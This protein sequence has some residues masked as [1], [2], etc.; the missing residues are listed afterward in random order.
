MLL[1]KR[2][3]VLLFFSFLHLCRVTIDS[4]CCFSY[5]RCT[6]K[7]RFEH[8][9]N[10]VDALGLLLHNLPF[11]KEVAAFFFFNLCFNL[12]GGES[13]RAVALSYIV[14]EERALLSEFFFLP[15]VNL[16]SFF[17]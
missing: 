10:R 6:V 14:E 15:L 2:A 5:T 7:K 4:F 13:K 12:V 11:T 8:I 3:R 17:F 1:R 16:H 9:L